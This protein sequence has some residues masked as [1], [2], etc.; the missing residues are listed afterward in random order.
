MVQGGGVLYTLPNGAAK[1]T[2]ARGP[3]RKKCHEVEAN[4]VWTGF[5]FR[6]G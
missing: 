6:M 5:N 1:Q 2:E 4:N 3:R